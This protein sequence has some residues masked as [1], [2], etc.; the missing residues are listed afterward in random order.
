MYKSV[1]REDGVWRYRRAAYHPNGKIKIDTVIVNGQEE[2]HEE[3]SYY[4]GHAGAWLPLGDD[5]LA[6]EKK[7]AM[8]RRGIRAVPE[9]S[10]SRPEA[11]SN[12]GTDGYRNPK[13]RQIARLRNAV[14][15]S[16][17][18]AAS[19]AG[20]VRRGSRRVVAAG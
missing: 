16:G 11:G 3:G 17:T 8:L 12:P 6:A 13:T 10:T 1:K 9:K 14:Q 7:A 19:T 15:R 4:A 20:R 2:V 18:R 5:A